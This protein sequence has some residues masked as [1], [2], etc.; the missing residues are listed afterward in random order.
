MIGVMQRI[1]QTV[2]SVALL[3][4]TPTTQPMPPIVFHSPLFSGLFFP[5][6]I[7][8]YQLLTT[9][10]LAF[11]AWGL[12]RLL[13]SLVPDEK[14]SLPIAHLS[15]AALFVSFFAIYLA[16]HR[17]Q[18]F[19]W[20]SGV[21]PYTFPLI[22]TIWIL[23]I[24][25]ESASRPLRPNYL[26]PATGLLAFFGAGFSEA[27]AT[28]LL[29][30]L[31]VTLLL[32]SALP[33][34]KSTRARWTLPLIWSSAWAT[35]AILLLLLSPS[36]W[37]RASR[38]GE[39]AGLFEFLSLTLRY[40]WDFVRLSL[41]DLPLPHLALALGAAFL[42]FLSPSTSKKSL[43]LEAPG[44]NGSDYIRTDRRILCPQRSDRKEPAPSPHPRAC[45]NHDAPRPLCSFL[46]IHSLVRV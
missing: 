32:V 12:F 34:F 4:D 23:V 22:F 24:I 19:H 37:E 39:L 35:F 8:A 29:S 40:S 45:A 20:L 10:L 38:Y 30:A 33:R 11:L 26:L 7:P 31:L 36:S 27:G 6:G 41:L 15:A 5:L 16:P 17:Y 21:L 2:V 9:L 18:S 3:P 46:S 44:F 1:S 28:F 42:A 25:F 43:S 13:R 14:P